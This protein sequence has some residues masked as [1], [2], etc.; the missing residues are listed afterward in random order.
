MCRI[1]HKEIRCS[2]CG[3]TLEMI[4]TTGLNCSEAQD[5]EFGACGQVKL[6]KPAVF[7]KKCERC[8]DHGD[9]EKS[10]DQNPGARN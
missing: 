1:N 5:L 6:G 7:F 9:G 10:A 8:P 2:T 3:E 4:P